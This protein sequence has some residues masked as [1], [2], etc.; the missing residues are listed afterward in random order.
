[1]HRHHFSRLLRCQRISLFPLVLIAMLTVDVGDGPVVAAV[2]V[3][4]TWQDGTDSDPAAPVYSENGVNLD[5][6]DDSDL[7]SAWFQGGGGSL[8]PAGPGGPLAMIMADG[9]TGTSSSSWTTYFTPEGSEV[10]LAN[11]GDK[12]R[13][14]WVF[15]TNE[16]SASNT[17]QNLRLA[18]VDSPAD[19]RVTE[20]GTPGSAAY[21]GYG[22]FGNMGETFD[23]GNPFELVE[24]ADDS[25]ALLSSSGEWEDDVLASSRGTEG[26]AG[27]SDNT[28]YEFVMELMRNATDGI[29]IVASMTGGNLDGVGSVSASATDADPTSFQ[30]DTF[31]LRPSGA[32]T[33]TDQFD[34]SLFRVEYIPIPEPASL[35]LLGVGGAALALARRPSRR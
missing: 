14:T 6:M 23:H 19:S 34:T 22:I 33:T 26:N 2:I 3:N 29:D 30:F 8:D 17:S 18:L 28:Q 20:D 9:P 11:P 12:L 21:T 4:D 24:R 35:L 31:A 10:S 5:P 16:V 7:E 1:M 27:Y 25:G 32:S 13:V 15:T